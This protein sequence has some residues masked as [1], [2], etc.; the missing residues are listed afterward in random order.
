MNLFEKPPPLFFK[1]NIF[2]AKYL[3]DSDLE[4]FEDE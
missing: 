3:Q 2:Y 4:E 1:S